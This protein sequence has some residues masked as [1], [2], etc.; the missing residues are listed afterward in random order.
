MFRLSDSISFN[1][2]TP[3]E[4]FLDGANTWTMTP[5]VYDVRYGMYYFTTGG[6]YESRYTGVIIRP[7][8]VLKNNLSLIGGDGSPTNP[9]IVN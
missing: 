4:P 6:F 7:A 1:I 2:S 9:Y 8:I 5:N 3:N